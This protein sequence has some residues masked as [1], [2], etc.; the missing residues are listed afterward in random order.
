MT[1]PRLVP[2]FIGGCGRSGTTLLGSILG[3]H[4]DCVCTPE[5][6]FK[7]DVLRRFD[8]APE[9]AGARLE[10]VL[11]NRRFQLW[12]LDPDALRTQAAQLDGSYA[13]L[14]DWLVRQYAEHVDRPAARLW[15]DHTPENARFAATLGE[16]FSAAKFVHI[17]RDGRG[18]AAS[19]LPLD[20]GPNTIDQ[21]ARWWLDA[22]GY[23]LAAESWGGAQQRT[24]R[25]RYE[26]LVLD[27][28]TTVRRLCDF[29][30]LD[31]QP[32]MLKA[33][34]FKV[35]GY[36]TKQHSLVGTAPQSG[37]VA[38]WE[39][40]LTTRQIE[41]FESVAGEM[42]RLLGYAPRFG[43]R[44]RKATRSENVLMRMRDMYS[45]KLVNRIRL[46][47]RKTRSS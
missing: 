17:V 22:V 35:P 4:R 27:A 45:A 9:H 23:G 20:W 41:I 25:V 14:L 42:L 5:S 6:P 7:T 16:L 1:E 39:C 31:F 43:L 38:A 40:E 19:I 32:D 3:A 47:Q 29:L 30:Q 26:D 12:G 46:R 18:V 13:T 11:R 10:F 28:E 15:I 8:L 33:D 2:V 34:G 21:A 24:L 36:S 37:R 44:A